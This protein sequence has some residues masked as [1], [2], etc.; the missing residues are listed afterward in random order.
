M[1]IILSYLE[2]PNVRILMRGSPSG[3]YKREGGGTIRGDT[4][5]EAQSRRFE[6]AKVL[7]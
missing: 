2:S 1:K 4:T 5:L 6:D 7:A 3:P